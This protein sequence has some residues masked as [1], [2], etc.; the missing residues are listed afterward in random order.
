[1]NTSN[2]NK[3]SN[4][5]IIQLESLRGIAACMIVL[6][7]LPKWNEGMNINFINNCYLMV[8]LFFV[9]SGFV[10]YNAYIGKLNEIKDLYK[11]IYLRFSR[12]YPVHLIF[13]ILFCD[14]L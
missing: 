2:I 8:D 6:A 13:L 3:F 5:K 11:F 10:I 4:N 1:M 12:L 14:I 9:L 7:H